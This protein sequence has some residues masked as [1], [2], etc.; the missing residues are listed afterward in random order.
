MALSIRNPL[1]EKLA[2]QVSKESGKNVTQSII[3]ALEEKLEKI[4]GRRSVPDIIEEIIEI[5]KRCSNLPDKD[6]R[7]PEEILGYNKKFGGL[8]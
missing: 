3:H 7:T 2:K 4:H 6:S 5:S 8:D 1:A